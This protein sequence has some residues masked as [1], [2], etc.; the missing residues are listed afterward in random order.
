MAYQNIFKRYEFKYLLT[1]SQKEKIINEMKQY[2]KQDEYGKSTICNIYFDTSDHILIRRSLEKKVYKEKL[3]VRSYGPTYPTGEVFV[4]LKKKYRSVV[5][6]RR[7]CLSEQEAMNYL[8]QREALLYQNQITHEIDYACQFYH[9]IQPSM[10]IAYQREAYYGQDDHDLRI[11]F[12]ENVLWRN[13][14]LSL[15]SDV[16]GESILKE[17]MVLMEVKIAKAMPLWL[18]KFLSD[19]KLYKISFSKYGKAYLSM[20]KQGGKKQYV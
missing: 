6:K 15:Q 20:L 19:N 13:Y 14:D 18:V 9:N 8:C 3:R 7:I 17:D 16:Y 4:E 2:M 1:K 10:Y 12:D 11:T 5:Y